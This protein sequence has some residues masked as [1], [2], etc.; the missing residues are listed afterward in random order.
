LS[1]YSEYSTAV[2]VLPALGGGRLADPGL[3]RWLAKADFRRLAR[4]RELLARILEVL[5]QPYPESGLGAL[6]MWGQTGERP[7]IWVA[8]ADPVYLEPRLDHLAV[9]AQDPESMSPADL[10]PLI[11]HLQATLAGD[12]SL[13]FARLGRYAYLRADLPI[14]TARVPP[15]VAQLDMPNEYLPSGREAAEYRR[16]TSEVEMALHEHPV[17]TRREQQGLQ[18]INGLW[19]WG[20]GRAPEQASLALPPLFA[21]DPLVTGFWLSRGGDAGDWRGGIASCAAESTGAFVAVV[22]DQDD[23]ALLQSCLGELKDLLGGGRVRALVLMF[24]DGIEARVEPGH[25]WR[26]W[27]RSLELPA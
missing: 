23:P 6:R 20:G 24:R 12:G 21:A 7:S 2:A 8:A 27:R 5:G 13:G 11:D 10:R 1:T 19:F 3:R 16:L 25:R 26:F 17:N 4:P 14:A 15:Y 9:H 18:P 22:P